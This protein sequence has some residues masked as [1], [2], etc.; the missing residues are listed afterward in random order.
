MNPEEIVQQIL[1]RHPELTREAVMGRLQIEKDKTGGL[2]ADATLLRLIAAE[3][4]VKTSPGN[5]CDRTLSVGSLIPNLNDVT[6]AG[7]IVAVYPVKTFEGKKSGK[8]ASLLVADADGVLRVMLWNDK[9]GLVESGK[10]EAGQVVRF[11]RGYTREDRD[12]KVELHVGEKSEVE[13]NP[14]DLAPDGYPEIS[15]F[16]AKISQMTE[17]QGNVHL[18]GTVRRV[19]ASS[20]FTR[21]DLSVGKVLRFT[22][23]D[24]SGEIMVVAWNEKAEELEAVL[25]RNV[26]VQLV[27]AVVKASA[28]D[29]FEVH[30][31]AATC[32]RVLSAAEDSRRI[33]DLR[34]DMKDVSVEGEVA[35]APVVREVATAKGEVVKLAVFELRDESGV[36]RVSAWREHAEV[37]GGLRVGDRVRLAG[38][39]VKKGF[40]GGLE[41]STRTATVLT[42][43]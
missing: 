43:L 36:V 33:A 30:V 16:V 42:R 8:Y 31:G 21:Q 35:V 17:P 7:R 37:A 1:L 9:A 38:V 22:L 5:V 18:A 3:Y 40:S 10:L 23:A 39:Y 27:N 25:S 6:V 20:T 26:K 14:S 13:I 41:L 15:R 34:E 29:G 19:F 24:D 28:N 32:V 12:G 11:V 4:G 2:I